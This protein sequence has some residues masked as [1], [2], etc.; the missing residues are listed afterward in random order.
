MTI[1]DELQAAIRVEQPISGLTVIHVPPRGLVPEHPHP[2][3]YIVV[4]LLPAELERITLENKQELKRE[5]LTL[6]PL[7]PYYVEATK[8]NQTISVVNK[9]DRFSIFQK[10]RPRPPI[11]GPQPP[12]PTRQVTVVSKGGRHTFTAEMAVTI[13][14]Q[15][16]G[17]MFREYLAPNSGM[18]FVWLPP[19]EVAM[20]MRNTR[21]SLDI[22]YIDINLEISHIRE[23]ATPEDPTPIPS[24]GAVL[25]TLEI[26]GGTAAKLG[27]RTGDRLE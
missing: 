27:I 22:L 23:N 21:V 13:M 26:A 10:Y 5:P 11:T 18:L 7:V 14:Q 19:R 16:V 8:A 15:A 1:K 6:L 3:G 2:E 25:F 12:L 17:L 24:K 4:P 20:Y 9:G